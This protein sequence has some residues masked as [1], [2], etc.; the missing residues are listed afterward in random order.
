MDYSNNEELAELAKN[1]DADALEKLVIQNTGLVKSIAARFAGRG[2][3]V[4]DLTQIGTIGL[5]K[6]ARSFDKGYGTV[7]STYAVPLITGEIKRFLR[8]D[9]MIKVSRQVKQ[10]HARLLHAKEKHLQ[11][12]GT[13]PTVSELANMCNMSLDDAVYALEAGSAVVS[14]DGARGDDEGELFDSIGVCEMD[15]VV[16]CIALKEAIS[17]LSDC[18]KQILALRYKKGLSQQKTAQIMGLTQVKISREEK[19]I[20]TALK[21]AVS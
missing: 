15:G 9:G 4:A 11:K 12:Y 14:L 16:E 18:H 7:L 17:K 13:E 3:D 19:K 6:A 1:G 20:F 2:H 10:N 5:I 21:E 8:D